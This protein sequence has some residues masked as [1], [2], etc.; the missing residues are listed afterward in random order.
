MTKA[1][2]FDLSDL[3]EEALTELYDYY[4]FLKQRY[5]NKT[6]LNVP[7]TALLSE[8]ALAADWNKPEEDEAWKDYQ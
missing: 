2:R 8:Q 5:G 3:P 1:E 4:L 6:F 7:E